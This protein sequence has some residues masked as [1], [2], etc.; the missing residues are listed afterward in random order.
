MVREYIS[1]RS[2]LVV[3]R[4]S[5][6]VRRSSFVV[7]RSS[8]V[9]RRSSFVVRRSSDPPSGGLTRELAAL[10]ACESSC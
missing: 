4:W 7:R 5:F 2:S 3:R 6:V 8:F 9:V 1:G 10:S